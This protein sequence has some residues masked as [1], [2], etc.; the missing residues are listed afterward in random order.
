MRLRTSTK[1]SGSAS[2]QSGIRT[3]TRV[4]LTALATGSRD[5]L[6]LAL[7]A[8]GVYVTRSFLDGS[9]AG[10]SVTSLGTNP[11]F[12]SDGNVRIETLL[13]EQNGDFYGRRLEV[14]VLERIRGQY[15]FPDAYSLAA[16]IRRDVEFTRGYFQTFDDTE[17]GRS[18]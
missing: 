12:E 5:G 8:M 10:A 7:P 9:T 6:P 17:L 13:L 3:L 14:D 15:V 18:D 1:R 11:T 16:R 4:L 2:Y